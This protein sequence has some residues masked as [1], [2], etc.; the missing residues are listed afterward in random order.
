MMSSDVQ[1]ETQSRRQQ[2]HAPLRTRG[3]RA[4]A[5]RSRW[6]RCGLLLVGLAAALASAAALIP[7]AVS[8]QPVGPQLTHTMT[9]GDL[10]VTIT[11][12]GTLESA[13]N[14]EIKCQARGA[15]IPVLWVI[16][17][18][19]EVKP[20]DELVRLGAL[21]FEDRV[22][23]I[24]KAVHMTRSQVER[25]KADVARATLAIQEYLEGRYQSEL[26]T[27]EKDLA[28][29]ESDL[30][31]AQ[32]VRDHVET[33]AERGYASQFDLEE[34]KFAVRRAELNVGVKK[35]EIDSLKDF[36]KAM[37]LETLHGNLNASKARYDAAKQRYK[38]LTAQLDLCKADVEYC[39]VMA[40]ESGLV[41]HPSAARW[42]NAPEIRE[43]GTV[44]TGQTLLLMPDLSQ[45]Q[46]K[47]GIRESLVDR[48]KPGMAA[49]VILP[50]RT[51]DGEISS[52]A[53]VTAP[54][55]W[56]T[57]NVARYDTI[58]DLPSVQGLKPGMSADVEVVVDRHEDVLTIPVAA[59]VE[60]AEGDFCWVQGVED[61]DRRSLQLGDTNDIYTV[62]EAGLKEGDKVFLN[63]LAFKE[64][65][66][67]VQET[68]E[69]EDSQTQEA[70][71]SGS[72]SPLQGATDA[73][74]SREPKE[75]KSK[76]SAESTAKLTGVQI[77]Q[78]ADKNGDGVLTIDEFAEKDRSRFEMIDTNKDGS[79]H[80]SELDAALKSVK[81]AKAE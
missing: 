67:M 20:E 17:S 2:P 23:E 22:S 33:M 59:L 34:A 68:R 30:R 57:G 35:T 28:I 43:G 41:I 26:M 48:V 52:V 16:E 55:G 53:S 27:L 64:A 65:Q 39:V 70:S 81:Q 56:W 1:S 24:S 25:A 71:E 9:R 4:N 31:T 10:I 75:E 73:E 61:A 49:K 11:E 8:S 47:V 77:I 79:V 38:Q 60:T 40:D 50:D 80:A 58:I 37:E 74:P 54:A 66:A 15:R 14:V 45:M 7:G 44:Y 18:G 62:V 69:K 12:K 51:L 32:N 36:T 72:E 19:T 5:P 29:I 78:R 3:E 76:P 63:P 6:W 21:E 42:K 13:E 46:V